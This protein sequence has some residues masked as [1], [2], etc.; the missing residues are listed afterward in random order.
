MYIYIVISNSAKVVSELA[1]LFQT[2]P[3]ILA[4]VASTARVPL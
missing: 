2:H 4:Q 1:G 3:S